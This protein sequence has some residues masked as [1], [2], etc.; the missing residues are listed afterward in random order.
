[1]GT[2]NLA[3]LLGKEYNYYFPIILILLCA[4]NIFNLYSKLIFSCM[5]TFSCCFGSSK[6]I[7]VCVC[8]LFL[9]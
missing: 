4:A 7:Y 9:F 8:F 6:Y 3:P 5:K 2:M 1:M